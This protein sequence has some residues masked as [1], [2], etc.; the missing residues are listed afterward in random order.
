MTSKVET[1]TIQREVRKGPV[2]KNAINKADY[3]LL[4]LTP[5][6]KKTSHTSLVW[7]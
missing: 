2:I 3:D 7:N 1:E 5:T 4:W 6:E